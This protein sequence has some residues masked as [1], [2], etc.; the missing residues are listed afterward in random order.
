MQSALEHMESD[1]GASACGL[2]VRI[3]N[4]A[5]LRLYR[6]TLAFHIAKTEVMCLGGE[7]KEKGGEGESLCV[8]NGGLPTRLLS[9][10]CHLAGDGVATLR[11]GAGPATALPCYRSALRAL[12]HAVVIGAAVRPS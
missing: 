7:E 3:G 2:H 4:R 8:F 11:H 10:L 12:V 6:D 9:C 1:Y 5:A